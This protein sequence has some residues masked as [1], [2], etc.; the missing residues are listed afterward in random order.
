M[1]GKFE[2]KI[3]ISSEWLVSSESNLRV[4]HNVEHPIRKFEQ[5]K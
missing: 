1:W 4:L 2:V 5:K 3:F